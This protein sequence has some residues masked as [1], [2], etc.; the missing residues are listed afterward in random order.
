[1]KRIKKIMKMSNEQFKRIIS[2]TKLVFREMLE[3]LKSAYIKLHRPAA[4]R[5]NFLTAINC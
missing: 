1:M 4:N 3:I 5:L 2:T